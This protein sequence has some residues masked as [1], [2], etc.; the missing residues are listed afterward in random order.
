MIT[1]SYVQS[2][3][4]IPCLVFLGSSQI[5]CWC[6]ITVLSVR[7]NKLIE[8]PSSIGQLQQLTILNVVGNR[9]QELPISVRGMQS[10]VAL[11]ITENQ[12]RN[13][14]VYEIHLQVITCVRKVHVSID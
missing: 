13:V 9:L 7:N 2:Q 11:W 12:V 6:S 8:L 10:L 3:Y 14:F 1:Y 5:G 4:I